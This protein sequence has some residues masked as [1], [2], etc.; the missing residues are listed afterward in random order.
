MTTS[1]DMGNTRPTQL[2][3]P[4]GDPGQVQQGQVWGDFVIGALLGKGGMGAVYRGRQI[5][6]D[7]PVAVKV[8][9]PHLGNNEQFKKRFLLEARSVAQIS[10]PHVVQVYAAGEH[11]GH[12][13]FAMEYVEGDD[14]SRRLRHGYRPTA[15]QALDLVTQAAKGLAAAGELGIVHRD[16]KPGNMMVTDKGLVKLM[17]FGLVRLARSEETG[18]TRAGT[19]M[20]TVSYFSPEQ[21]RGEPCDQRTDIYALGVVFYELLTGTLPF[22]GDDATSIIYQHIHVPPKAP[23]AINP[24]VP[25]DFQAVVLKCLQ[26][27]AA[28]RYQNAHELLSDLDDLRLGNTPHTAFLD[29]KRLRFGA[30]MVRG[31]EFARERARRQALLGVA[32][33]ALALI[34][35]GVWWFMSRAQ[36]APTTAAVPAPLVVR[37]A[38]GPVARPVDAPAP[39]ATPAAPVVVPVS[40]PAAANGTAALATARVHIEAGRLADCRTLVDANRVAHPDDPAWTT[41]AR[42]L[43]QAEGAAALNEATAAFNRGDEVEAARLLTTA[44]RHTP[45]DAAVAA[46][47]QRLAQRNEERQNRVRQIDE[48]RTLTTEGRFAA[49][50]EVLERLKTAHPGD[51]EVETT[52]RTTQA[53]RREAEAKAKAIAELLDKG[54]QALARKDYDNAITMLSMA[55]KDD[56][57]NVRARAG[58]DTAN[59]AKLR[60][61]ELRNRIGR[62]VDDRKLDEADALLVELTALAPS[63]PDVVVAQKRIADARH[64]EAL[65]RKTADEREAALVARAQAA[66]KAL[67]DA[68]VPLAEGEAAHQRFLDAAGGA[69]RP[70]KPLLARKLDDRRQ[71]EQAVAVLAALDQSVVKKDAAGIRARVADGAFAAALEQLGAYAGLTFASRLDGFTRQDGSAEATVRIRHA[72][73]VFPERTLTYRYGLR[74]TDQGWVVASAQLVTDKP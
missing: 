13:Y 32:G 65:A 7:R 59:Q 51:A 57:A 70:E 15:A 37:P 56:P 3:A 36:P 17:D 53:K 11:E 42:Q 72:L 44:R 63:S 54:E 19:I 5:S 66:A 16:I 39:L 34:G 40:T 47:A 50:E 28:H 41:L 71:R 22:T 48:A 38:E 6:L 8:L 69:E 61:M 18:L 9:P 68:T 35:G 26:K 30:T 73:A 10:S 20:G 64:Q 33:A 1:G 55:V 29:A 31:D 12:H 62:A 27:D 2:V 24:A 43:D 4:S 25:E 52:L 58:F 60:M 14:L 46:L 74:Q 67:D 23:R 21:G 45:E 49:A